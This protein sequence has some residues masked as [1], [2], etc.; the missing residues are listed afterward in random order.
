M[1]KKYIIIAA[2]IPIVLASGIAA[3]AYFSSECKYDPFTGDFIW[4]GK[5]YAYGTM[6]DA[7]TCALEGLLPNIVADRLGKY[8][9]EPTKEEAS[10]ILEIDKANKQRRKKNE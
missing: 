2:T 10:K 4:K 5:T 9:D 1:N 6:A 7:L 8:G 3:S